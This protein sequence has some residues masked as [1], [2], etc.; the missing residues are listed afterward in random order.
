MRLK[1]I[2]VGKLKDGAERDLSRR[3][4]DRLAR[5]GSAIGLEFASVIDLSESRSKDAATRKRDEADA[6][7]R[8]LAPDCAFVALDERGRDDGSME[9]AAMI[10]GF[11][12]A[13]RRELVF[14]IGGADGLDPSLRS[15]AAAVWRFGRMTWPHQ[16][17]RAMLAEQLYRAAMILSG[18]PYH[19]S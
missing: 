5:S 14:V 11:R 1:I 9:F 13:G 4:I 6:I 10:A 8:H 18:H 15:D 19:R 2:A 7:R 12:D 16:M 17:V 3:Y